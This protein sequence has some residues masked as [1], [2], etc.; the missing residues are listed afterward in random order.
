MTIIRKFP[1]T[2]FASY[3][4]RCCALLPPSSHRIYRDDILAVAVKEPRG[5]EERGAGEEDSHA[6]R[7]S[8]L[9]LDPWTKMHANVTSRQTDAAPRISPP[10]LTMKSFFVAA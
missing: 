6:A 9:G 8:I 3:A 4:I 10:N 2:S 1:E 7:C 5:G